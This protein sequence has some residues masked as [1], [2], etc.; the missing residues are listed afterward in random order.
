MAAMNPRQLDSFLTST[1][2]AGYN[3]I[4]TGSPG[5]GKTDIV[6][7]V[8]T[9]LGMDLIVSHPAV[10]DPTSVAGLPWMEPGDTE[11]TF[12][13][14]GNIAQVLK[15]TRPTAWLLDDFGQSTPATQAAYMQYFWGG[16][17][18]GHK[19]PSCVTMLILTNRRIDRAGVSGILETVKSRAVSIVELETNIDD[20]SQWAFGHNVPPMGIAFLRFRPELL[21]AFQPTADLTN[22]PSPRTWTN[23]FK[24]EALNLPQDI[25]SIAM[26]GAVGEGAATEYLAFRA[27]ANSLVNLDEILMNPDSAPIPVKPD[28]L[29]AT[30]IG[31][32]GRANAKN[33]SRV[34]T[35]G[36]RLVTEP[37]AR[38]NTHGEFAVLMVRSA[39]DRDTPLKRTATFTK[40]ASGPIG[41]L[42]LG[43]DTDTV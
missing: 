16:E 36:E 28:Q 12:R 13:P 8:T 1:L 24:L 22:S 43:K 7:Q 20:Y 33:F 14:F 4:V 35:Y 30:C 34:I 6:R 2:K 41:A 9:L 10:E 15:A 31:L 39:T 40:M 19:L 18:N 27:M 25:E 23:C 21:S 11:A 3:V 29:Y 5:I 17:L 42:Y 37:D 26:A 32:A 38:G